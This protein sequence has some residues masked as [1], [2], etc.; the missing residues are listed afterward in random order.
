MPFFGLIVVGFLLIFFF[1]S[2]V[3]I[4]PEYERVVIFRLGRVLGHEKGPGLFILI[5]MVDKMIRVPIRTITMAID[6]QDV[7]TRDNV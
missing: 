3:K 2:S 7:I 6:P 1:F 5:P 4:V